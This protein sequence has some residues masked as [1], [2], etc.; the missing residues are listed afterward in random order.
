MEL[1]KETYWIMQGNM[2]PTRPLFRLR[3]HTTPCVVVRFL[4]LVHV[5]QTETCVC[6]RNQGRNFG[7]DQGHTSTNESH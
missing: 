7:V 4:Y 5:S 6:R 2:R 1:L 3:L